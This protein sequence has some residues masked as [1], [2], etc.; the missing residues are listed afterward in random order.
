MLSLEKTN[1]GSFARKVAL[2]E[3]IHKIYEYKPLVTK[4]QIN[5]VLTL[6]GK[7]GLISQRQK[8]EETYTAAKHSL[9]VIDKYKDLR[10]AASGHYNHDTV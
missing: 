9:K 6:A 8:L 7:R 1:P 5:R 4:T 2:K 3:M 10:N